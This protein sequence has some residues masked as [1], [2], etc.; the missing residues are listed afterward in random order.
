MH[1]LESKGL[2]KNCI[3]IGLKEVD[4][5]DYLQTLEEL[6]KAKILT[7]EESNVFVTRN[8]ASKFA[9]QQGY[10]PELVWVKLKDLLPG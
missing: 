4:E 9:I 3:R 10:E 7:L 1:A 5:S 2:T 6:L 8:K